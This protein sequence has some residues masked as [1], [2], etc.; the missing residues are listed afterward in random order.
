LLVQLLRLGAAVLGLYLA[1]LGITLLAVP[2]G[3]GQTGPLDVARASSSLYLTEPKYVFMERSRL[4]TPTDKLLVLGASNA[5]VGF[6]RSELQELLPELEV[7]NISVGGS[8]ITQLD[9]I[10]RLVHEV[11][12]PAARRHDTF[13]LGL[14]YGV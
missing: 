8:N 13:V 5:L 11:Q 10:V 2:L 1:I 7:N 3:H 12:S 6:K 9:Q 14:W 4:D